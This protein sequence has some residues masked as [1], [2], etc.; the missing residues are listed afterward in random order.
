MKTTKNSLYVNNLSDLK[1]NLQLF[2]EESIEPQGEPIVD[3]QTTE[4]TQNTPSYPEY[5]D[6]NGE[7][8]PFEELTK[9]Y[10]RQSD[11]TKKTT[12]LSRQRQ[13]AQEALEL[14]Q[15]LNENPHVAQAMVQ[16]SNGEGVSQ[17][18]TPFKKEIDSI[19]N[20]LYMDKLDREINALKSKYPD[21]NEEEV[22]TRA[23]QMGISDLEFVHNSIRG[24]NIDKIVEQ[25][26]QEALSKA[27]TDMQN[28]NAQTKTMIT[29]T[30][31][32]NKDV[33][34]QLSAK[35]IRIAENFG[36]TPE[37]YAKWRDKA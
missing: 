31:G 36:M 6:V 16:A 4:P 34:I 35:E 1:I 18:F 5:V 9:G 8:I 23:N 37:E 32:M 26:V 3:T 2:A 28:N 33:P 14:V 13:E 11:Y 25:R 12:E 7:Q 10:L 17:D 30:D 21:F 19:K 15:F 20:E 24:Q 29:G 22:L 27:T